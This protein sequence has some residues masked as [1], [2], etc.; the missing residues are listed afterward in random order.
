MS[1]PATPAQARD[2][3]AEAIRAVAPDA[4]LE[5]VGRDEDLREA[6]DLDSID[7]LAVVEHL[8]ER[9]GL[10]IDEDDYAELATVESAVAFL[11]RA[12]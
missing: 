12:N 11:A 8:T 5:H 9:T 2:V 1:R 7:F 10:R 4:D 6:F 3:L